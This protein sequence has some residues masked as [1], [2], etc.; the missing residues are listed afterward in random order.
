MTHD[1]PQPT[2]PP[3]VSTRT[4]VLSC[5]VDTRPPDMTN[6]PAAWWSV[7]AKTS[8]RR[9]LMDA[10]TLMCEGSQSDRTIAMRT[11][12]ARRSVT[13]ETQAQTQTKEEAL[14]RRFVFHPFT[15]LD[16]HAASDAPVIVS[17]HGSTLT[18]SR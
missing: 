7:R 11:R 14:D 8:T 1:S 9:I 15:K 17:G 10:R 2:R 4:T 12:A 13:M 6:G 5:S 3:S 16:E 18:D